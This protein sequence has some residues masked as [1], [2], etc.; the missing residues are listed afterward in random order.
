MQA[1]AWSH[2]NPVGIRWG[3]GCRADLLPVLVQQRCLIVG[4]RGGRLRLEA[5]PVLASAMANPGLVWVDDVQANPDLAALQHQVDANAHRNIEAV[6]A[7]GGGSVLDSAKALAL[8]L[9]PAAAGVPIR[10]LIANGPQ[11]P[12]GT[13]LP[14]YALPTTAGTGSEVTPFATVWD[15]AAQRKLSLAGPAMFPR[16]AWVDPE[17]TDGLALDV[18]LATGLDAINQAAESIWNKHM[19][20]ITEAFAQ[21]A[22]VLGFEALPRLLKDPTD[23]M[24]R[25]AMAQASVLSGLAISQTRTALCHS[26]SYPLTAHFGVPHGWACAFTMPAVLRLN[27]SADDGRLQRLEATLNHGQS[28]SLSLQDRFEQLHVSMDVRDRVKAQVPVLSDLTALVSEMFTPGRAD[29]NLAPIDASV[30]ERVLIESWAEAKAS[31]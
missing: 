5:D 6:V 17:L 20:P 18:T 30:I 1:Q 21:R 31:V 11:Y 13:A 27:R 23:T 16:F 19:T 4:S 7:V 12:W 2:A 10:Q 22:L 14:L 9:S 29:N 25:D 28:L 8:A 15:H 26:M 3:R 24:A